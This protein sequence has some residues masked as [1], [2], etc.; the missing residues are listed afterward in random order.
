MPYIATTRR[1]E[2]FKL[3]SLL[4]STRMDNPGELNYVITQ[5]F[6]A[7]IASHGLR[8]QSIND[9]LGAAQGAC[10][11]LYR[12]VAANL[13]DRKCSENGDVFDIFDGDEEDKDGQV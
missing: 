6:L 7:Y 9:C 12:R 3:E 10:L 13:E 4:T 5:C 8:Y 1:P 2:F 11:E